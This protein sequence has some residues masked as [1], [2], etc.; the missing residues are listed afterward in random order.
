MKFSVMLYLFSS[1][2]QADAA[3]FAII[4]VFIV[5]RLQSLENDFDK[6]L[7]ILID[8]TKRHG[9]TNDSLMLELAETRQEFE[10]TLKTLDT[11]PFKALVKTLEDLPLAMSKIRQSIKLPLV[12]FICHILLNSLLLASSDSIGGLWVYCE[13]GISIAFFGVLLVLVYRLVIQA[14]T[15]PIRD[16]VNQPSA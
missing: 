10:K 2:I 6:S 12:L 15:L 14:L 1:F 11:P 9:R 16:I 8:W 3:I 13:L 4:G 5:Y 7:R